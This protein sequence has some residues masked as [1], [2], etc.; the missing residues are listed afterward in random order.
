MAFQKNIFGEVLLPYEIFL[1]FEQNHILY[2]ENTGQ[3]FIQI[4]NNT[5]TIFEKKKC[6]ILENNKIQKGTI[7]SK[8]VTIVKIVNTVEIEKNGKIAEFL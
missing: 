3:S 8:N 7:C 6:E 2:P 1:N 5:I 4:Q